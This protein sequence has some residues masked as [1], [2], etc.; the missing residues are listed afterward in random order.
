MISATSTPS[1]IAIGRK[2]HGEPSTR[3]AN[4]STTTNGTTNAISR[5]HGSLGSFLR[6]SVY[7]C[8]IMP[9]WLPNR[10][11]RPG[12]FSPASL[13]LRPGAALE[14]RPRPPDAGP[15]PALPL[16][17]GVSEGL[18]RAMSPAHAEVADA[19]GPAGRGDHPVAL[20]PADHARAELR[21]R[22][23]RLVA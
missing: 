22:A 11:S 15:R 1:R 13:P 14:P 12:F 3:I 21:D 19:A 7:A 23:G 16:G 4:S 9:S 8:R 5:I 17:A 6:V 20:G 10:F 18:L 2:N